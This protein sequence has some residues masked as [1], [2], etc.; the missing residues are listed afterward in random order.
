[1]DV[2]SVS[3][4]E[5]FK[6]RVDCSRRVSARRDRGGCD[7]EVNGAGVT[8][9]QEGCQAIKRPGKKKGPENGPGNGGNT[10]QTVEA[11]RGQRTKWHEGAEGILSF[12]FSE[13]RNHKRH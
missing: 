2:L 1:M 3:S 5:R 7:G 10:Q 6:R 4:R 11:N 8:N 13:V 12:G 9:D